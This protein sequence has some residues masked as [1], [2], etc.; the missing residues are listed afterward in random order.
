MLWISLVS[1]TGDQ[2]AELGWDESV[3]RTLRVGI[4]GFCGIENAVVHF[5]YDSLNVGEAA[6]ASVESALDAFVPQDRGA[7]QRSVA[8]SDRSG[9]VPGAQ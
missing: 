2:F 4:S 3:A 5:V 7:V 8:N 6:F 1:Y 9:S